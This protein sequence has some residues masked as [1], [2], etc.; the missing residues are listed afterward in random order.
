ML[1]MEWEVV[2]R[3]QDIKEGVQTFSEKRL[4]NQKKKV[5]GKNKREFG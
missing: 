2:G 4:N 5:N 1:G 3:I